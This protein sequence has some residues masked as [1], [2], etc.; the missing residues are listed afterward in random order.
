[1][2]KT[3][4][5][6]VVALLVVALLIPTLSLAAS[7]ATYPI[8]KP[9]EI[10]KSLS[11]TFLPAGAT[12]RA[13]TELDTRNAQ[14]KLAIDLAK[15][16][17]F[18]TTSF[19]DSSSTPLAAD[20]F[21]KKGGL[22]LI[23]Y[24][25]VRAGFSIGG[26]NSG[27]WWSDKSAGVFGPGIGQPKASGEV[28]TLTFADGGKALNPSAAN[29]SFIYMDFTFAASGADYATSGYDYTKVNAD[30][31]GA[32]TSANDALA[33]A[34][35]DFDYDAGAGTMSFSY[36]QYGYFIVGYYGDAAAKAAY[37]AAPADDATIDP[38]NPAA[39]KK[40]TEAP[41]TGDNAVI[42]LVVLMGVA[43]AGA[44]VV[45]RRKAN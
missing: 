21:N 20:K 16:L 41:P 5:I 7:G 36:N 19:K 22:D 6:S 3:L 39:T 34:P 17:M 27:A 2:S 33:A 35:E 4:R 40:P 12:A 8:K 1:M 11:Y 13:S 38:G 26:K 28:F 42:A 30:S 29:F 10:F 25:V 15:K 43:A 32:D 23:D 45:L 44:V 9:Q 18:E 31:L 24:W 37:N 14:D